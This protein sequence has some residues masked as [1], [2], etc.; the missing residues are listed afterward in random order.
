MKSANTDRSRYGTQLQTK[1]W[2]A[3]E[4]R[5]SCSTVYRATQ[6]HCTGRRHAKAT[7]EDYQLF[8]VARNPGV[9]LSAMLHLLAALVAANMSGAPAVDARS[10]TRQ[11][12][13]CLNAAIGS[14]RVALLAGT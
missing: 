10:V 8:R 3:R 11:F 13:S 5:I 7:S 6:E 14:I 4:D 9:S 1:A 12:H 2:R